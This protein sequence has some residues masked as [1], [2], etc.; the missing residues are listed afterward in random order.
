VRVLSVIPHPDD[1]CLGAPAT[2]LALRDAGWEVVVQCRARQEGRRAAELEEACRRLGFALLPASALLD[3]AGYDLVAGPS[4]HERHPTHVRVFEEVR[5]ARPA[6]WWQWGLWGELP[7]PTT[8]VG[9]DRLAEIEHAL[10]AHVSQ[11]ERNDFRRLLRGRALMDGVRAPELL[12]G[13]G[14]DALGAPYGELTT[15]L[16]RDGDAWALGPP[17]VLD[18]AR[19]FGR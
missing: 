4:P 9:E 15:E 11:L 5:E 17:R 1:E 14:A 8:V 2:L 6:R 10:E 7:T 12:F 16:L 3:V 13:F 18:P 19:P